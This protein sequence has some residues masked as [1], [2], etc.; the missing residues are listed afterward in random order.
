M[1]R[2]S[3]FNSFDDDRKEPL[4]AFFVAVRGTIALSKT[5][6]FQNI[7]NAVRSYIFCFLG[8]SLLVG[9]GFNG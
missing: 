1:D 2:F 4:S 3:S 9:G 6:L 5:I 7:E 8:T